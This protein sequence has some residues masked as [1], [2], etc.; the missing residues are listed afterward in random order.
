MKICFLYGGQGSQK[1]GMGKDFYD[2]YP[3]FKDFY[4][5]INLHFDLK[6][7]SFEKSDEEIAQTQWVVLPHQI[8]EKL[9]SLMK[10]F[11]G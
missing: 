10:A 11:I 9:P 7:Y 5:S 2:N 3:I 6:E 8:S 4:E 1:M